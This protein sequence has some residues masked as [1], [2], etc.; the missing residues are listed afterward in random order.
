[1]LFDA[2]ESGRS[3]PVLLDCLRR[4]AVAGMDQVTTERN[5][6]ADCSELYK[7]LLTT[8]FKLSSRRVA[9]HSSPLRPLLCSFV[10]NFRDGYLCN[11]LR[12]LLVREYRTSV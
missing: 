7:E 4:N 3:G 6:V 5:Y 1:M 12:N 11:E 10:N 9:D 8:R 2:V